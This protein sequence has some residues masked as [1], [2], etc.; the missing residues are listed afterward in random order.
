M[1]NKLFY[2]QLGFKREKE[3][4]D[5][6]FIT[7][8]RNNNLQE[9]FTELI[10]DTKNFDVLSGYFYLS[11]FHLIYKSLEK[12][13]KIRILIVMNT[14]KKTIDLLN[15]SKKKDFY[16]IN[17]IKNN[18]KEAVTEEIN[19]C[20]DKKY[21]EEGIIKFIQWIK[22]GK[23]QIKVYPE[24]N[25]HAKVYIMTFKEGDRDFGRVITGSSNFTYGGL[26]NN[27]EFNVELKNKSDYDFALKKFEELW[28]KSVEV[29][30]EY[31][32]TIEQK[33]WINE[34]IS[35]Y[36]LYLKFLYEYFKEDLNIKDDVYLK[37]FP[38]NF[39]QLEY[40]VQAV[41]NAKKI[42]EEYG[43]V[44]ISDVV[45]LGKTYITVI[46]AS[47]LQGRILVIA[48]P[49]LLDKNNPGSW[50]NA[51]SD[52]NIS[53]DFESTGKLD[54]LIK[55]DLSKFDT[56]IIDEAHKF[57]NQTTKSYE[58]LAQICK[59]KK[60]I[61]VTATP[62]NNSLDDIESLIR[63]FQ[64]FRNSNIP[65]LP[66]LENYFSK[67]RTEL[68]KI[69]K[70]KNYVKFIQKSKKQ[71]NDIREKILKH[72]MVRR[73]RSEIEKY[74]QNDLIKQKV[75]FP[76]VEKPKSIF[77]EL[78]KDEDIIFNKTI[79]L[80]KDKF[81]YSRYNAVMY[82]KDKDLTLFEE[83]SQRNMVGFIKVLI[84]KRLESSFIAFKN[85]IQ[86]MITSYENT[87][88]EFEKENGG[89]YKS[90]SYTNKIY[91]YLNISDY[92]AI[93]KLIDEEKAEFYK[94][95]EFNDDFIKD[96]KFDLDL[97]KEIQKKWDTVKR[98]PKLLT[99]KDE[100]KTNKL[101]SN[102]IIIF[103]ESKETAE[104][105]KDELEKENHKVICFTGSSD[106]NLRE[107]VIDNF[108]N[109]AINKKN[110]YNILVATEVL[111]EGVN[112]HA[113]NVIINYDIP[114]NPTK[115]MQR[116]GR[117]N[118][119]DTPFKNI[120]VFNFFPS[121]QGNEAIKLE[122]TAKA[123]IE[124]FLSLLGADSALL[125]ETE[126]IE[127]F[128]LF[129]KL[130][131]LQDDE[132]WGELKYLKVIKDVKE[133]NLT[134]YEKIKHLPIRARSSKLSKTDGLITYF[135]LGKIEKFLLSLKK[136]DDIKATEIDFLNAAS[137]IECSENDK[138][139]KIK[140]NFYDLLEKNKEI[141]IKSLNNDDESLKSKAD[142]YKY[143]KLIKQLPKDEDEN[144][145]FNQI[146]EVIVDGGLPKQLISTLT[147][148]FKDLKDEINDKNRV[149]EVLKTTIHKDFLQPHYHEHY[150]A[151][152]TKKE[153]VLSMCLNGE[154]NE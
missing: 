128:E 90:K 82:L 74:F 35:P 146:W 134:L 145:Y 20:D 130:T 85:T 142:I 122:E 127:S 94:N 112:L 95:D 1:Q 141:F 72:L 149:F 4:T 57:R 98:D 125:T 81:K 102:K 137:L 133:N 88:K 47:M 139:E 24:Q 70:K 79:E 39:K 23:L 41:L 49:V 51:F 11:G 48:P 60:V 138:K 76:K 154:K 17:D 86:R 140:E 43:G 144:Y 80:L 26:L 29:T 152:K 55:R 36:E 120:Y 21:I 104:Y 32:N 106:I 53:A 38:K 33:T 101:L 107:I 18:S 19:N 73:T 87:I 99:F 31:V 105:L 136:D 119:V 59:G 15:E 100:L 75:S 108:D 44:F 3:M 135:R 9:R 28:S 30:D 118:R 13:E 150:K 42:I 111:A 103:T 25:I 5:L 124:A 45:G 58:K 131:K 78:S 126:N 68:S 115:M 92:E 116:V 83:Q 6:T 110:D 14:D 12:T 96:L 50:T 84:V 77:Y 71:A 16:S 91:D 69:D 143:L 113:S 52:F 121:I 7:N 148:K 54:A 89:F 8:Q 117:I 65:N 132:E 10:K 37:Y 64:N 40:Q 61:L 2:N 93:Y 46:L 56:V 123:K 147:T 62:Y 27:L 129:E 151:K 66:N 34:N 153:V 109:K 22:S 97:L 67:L 63:L 114:W